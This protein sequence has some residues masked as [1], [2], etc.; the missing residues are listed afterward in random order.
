MKY[1]LLIVML[2]A[3]SACSSQ[4]SSP[5]EVVRDVVKCLHNKDLNGY[6]QHIRYGE[7]IQMIRNIEGNIG[8]NQNEWISDEILEIIS[9][10]EPHDNDQYHLNFERAIYPDF[11]L[12]RVKTIIRYRNGRE[13]EVEWLV[14]R[15]DGEWM[16]EGY[17]DR[18]LQI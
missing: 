17:N 2:I 18:R 10:E 9:V 7:R 16:L 15:Q 14:V 4:N 13:S 11:D 5:E 1:F 12:R 8:D 6:I 3:I